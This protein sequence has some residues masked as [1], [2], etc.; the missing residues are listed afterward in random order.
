V[1]DL[2]AVAQS[3]PNTVDGGQVLLAALTVSGTGVILV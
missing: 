1:L 2:S 3:V